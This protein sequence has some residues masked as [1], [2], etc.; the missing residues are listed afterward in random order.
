METVFYVL[1]ILFV[2][3]RDF[4]YCHSIFKRENQTAS[5]TAVVPASLYHLPVGVMHFPH[6]HTLF[7]F[8][9]VPR[10][11]FFFIPLWA[12]T[13]SLYRKIKDIR[14]VSAWFR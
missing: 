8:G 11:L 10:S 4:R 13:L 12:Y 9:T 3:C 1:L 14:Q 5:K 2:S 7:G 6:Q